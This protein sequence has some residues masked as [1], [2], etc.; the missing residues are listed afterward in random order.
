MEW[1]NLIL[2]SKRITFNPSRLFFISHFISTLHL[3]PYHN[4][5]PL[6]PLSKQSIRLY[7][8]VLYIGF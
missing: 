3:Y 1:G 7:T 4:L 5:T 8:E 6:N 2:P